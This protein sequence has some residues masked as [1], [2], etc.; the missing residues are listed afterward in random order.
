MSAFGKAT[1]GLG[2]WGA[3][4]SDVCVSIR[5]P[6]GW[7]RGTPR[8]QGGMAGLVDGCPELSLE[9][10]GG[11]AVR[12]GW[13]DGHTQSILLSTPARVLAGPIQGRQH[14]P[15]PPPWRLW[16]PPGSSQC[17]GWASGTSPALS[18]VVTCSLEWSPER[19]LPRPPEGDAA[20]QSLVSLVRSW[21]SD[22]CVLNSFLPSPGPNPPKA[23]RTALIKKTREG[24]SRGGPVVENLPGEARDAGSSPGSGN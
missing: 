6:Q 3:S 13:P 11:L 14:P 15:H 22:L 5:L 17:P 16:F 23:Q 2:G 24:T 20:L 21:S 4:P 12:D 19:G 7:A 18:R 10:R 9:G 8:E 1:T